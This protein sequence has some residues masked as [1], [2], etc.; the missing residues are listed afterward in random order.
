MKQFDIEKLEKAIIYAERMADG[1]APYSNQPVDNEVLNNPNVIRSMYF[2]KEV[3]QEVKSNGGIVGGKSVGQSK[4]NA[5]KA[6]EFP[7]EV[8]KQFS[9]ESNKPISYV[10]RQF[11]ELTGEPDIP[12]LSAVNVNKWLEANGYITK[13]VVNDEGK[14]NWIPTDKGTA[15]GLV[16][17]QRGEPGREYIRIE[18]NKEAQEFLA[19]NLRRITED[20]LALK[21]KTYKGRQHT[22]QESSYVPQKDKSFREDDKKQQQLINS[23]EHLQN[24]QGTEPRSCYNCKLYRKEECGGIN[25]LCDD[26]EYAP[27]TSEEE[28]N[29]WPTEMG[30]YVTGYGRGRH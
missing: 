1:R 2:I 6:A 3:L 26:Y 19:N 16:A 18:Y 8:L 9:Y 13:S 25:G 7:F 14:E 22:R 28:L 11:A 17:E 5:A 24:E 30:P 12:I 20:C 27:T 4:N 10:L 29:S 21:N 15:L 23:S